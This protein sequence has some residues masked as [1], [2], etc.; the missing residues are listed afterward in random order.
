MVPVTVPVL[1]PLAVAEEVPDDS[2]VILTLLLAVIDALPDL[3]RVTEAD[4]VLVCDPV[5]EPE[6]D[7]VTL[8]DA[9]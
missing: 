9:V 3:L 7:A 1:V 8:L 4:S 5:S 6:T 2:G